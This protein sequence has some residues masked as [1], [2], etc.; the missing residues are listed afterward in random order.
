MTIKIQSRERNG[1]FGRNRYIPV[2][3]CRICDHEFDAVEVVSVMMGDYCTSCGHKPPII[4]DKDELS[5]K[6]IRGT[7]LSL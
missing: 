3:T 2:N 5:N 6:F 1:Q 4:W 7:L